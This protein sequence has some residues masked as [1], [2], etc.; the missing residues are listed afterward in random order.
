MPWQYVDPLGVSTVQDLMQRYKV[1]FARLGQ[2]AKCYEQVPSLTYG[3]S[4]KVAGELDRVALLEVTNAVAFTIEN[5]TRPREGAQIVLDIYNNSGGVMGAITWGSEYQLAGAMTN[6][7]N[8]KHRLI[9]FYR[10]KDAKWR[11][12]YRSVADI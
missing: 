4:I 1:L 11:E 10:A 8:T 6:P 2:Q 7:A 5:P 12:L 9:A 3:T